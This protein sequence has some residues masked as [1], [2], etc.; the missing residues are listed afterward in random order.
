MMA[1][2]RSWASILARRE[3]TSEVDVAVVVEVDV[4]VVSVELDEVLEDD[5]AEVAPEAVCALFRSEI[6]A[7]K[8][9]FS[10]ES[11]DEVEAL[12]VPSSAAVRSFS[13]VL[14]SL[15]MAEVLED[16]DDD[17]ESEEDSDGGGGGGG[18]LPKPATLCCD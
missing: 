2:I 11:L 18:R 5:E 13:R 15:L 10:V 12:D 4:A 6:R 7:S 8:S 16:E 1:F 17:E 9:L 3:S 14:M